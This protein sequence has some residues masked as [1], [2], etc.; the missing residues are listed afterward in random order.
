M[1][2]KKEKNTTVNQPVITARIETMPVAFYAGADPVIYHEP[3]EKAKISPAQVTAPT[4]VSPLPAKKPLSPPLRQASSTSPSD[5]ANKEKIA[6]QKPPAASKKSIFII[7]AFIFILFLAGI[8]YYVFFAKSA[9]PS[10]VSSTNETT[11]FKPSPVVTPPIVTTTL[12]VEIATTTVSSTPLLRGGGTLTLPHIAY[13]PAKDD[14]GDS[15]TNAEEEVFQT[16]PEVYD[17]DNDGYYDGQEVANLYNPKGIAPQKIIDSGLVKEYINPSYQ[18]RFY[19]PASWRVD[20]VADDLKD[21]LVSADSGD[22]MEIRVFPKDAALSFA[23]WFGAT[24]PNESFSSFLPFQ[25][26]FQV[27]A[28]KRTDAQVGFFETPTAIYSIVYF[29]GEQEKNAFPHIMNVLLQSFR[30]SKNGFELPVQVILPGVVSSTFVSSSPVSIISTSTPT[31][32]IPTTTT[33]PDENI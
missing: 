6:L 22:Y 25:N 16:D 33:S 12:P 5:A 13:A 31:T 10:P 29:Y 32:T 27:T 11:T 18:Y 7:A 4:P 20:P 2:G 1:F 9:L 28:Y 14:D 15:L 26:R 30:T 8:V 23:D 3:A 24:L 21:I 19:Y 17:M